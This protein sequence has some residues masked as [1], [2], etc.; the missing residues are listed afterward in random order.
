MICEN[1]KLLEGLDRTIHTPYYEIHAVYEPDGC[2]LYGD[3]YCAGVDLLVQG[4]TFKVYFKVEG[5]NE[6]QIVHVQ[7]WPFG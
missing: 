4:L 7:R 1:E 2:G 3:C 5:E 6:I